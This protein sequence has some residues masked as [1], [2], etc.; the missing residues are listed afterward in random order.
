MY[1][2]TYV[3]IYVYGYIVSMYVCVHA[4]S[5][6]QWCHMFTVVVH[7]AFIDLYWDL[8]HQFLKVEKD[9]FTSAPRPPPKEKVNTTPLEP[10]RA[11]PEEVDQRPRVKAL[12][13][14]VPSCSLACVMYSFYLLLL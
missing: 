9:L 6:A 1:V 8:Y 2:C 11:W 12:V 3:N 14:F 7:T 13:C 5:Q 4:C 10:R